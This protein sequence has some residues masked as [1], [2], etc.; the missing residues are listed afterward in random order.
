LSGT[1]DEETVKVPEK[2]PVEFTIE[3]PLRVIGAPPKVAVN[4]EPAAKPKPE[5]VTVE[6]AGPNI[7]DREIEG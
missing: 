4:A 7:G 5:T 3:A 1:E 6:P 2:C